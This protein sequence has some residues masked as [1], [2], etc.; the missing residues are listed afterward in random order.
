LAG[1]SV[2]AA[3]VPAGL[4]AATQA[5]IKALQ[6]ERRDALR[7]AIK[8]TQKAYEAGRVTWDSFVRVSRRLLD[9]ELALATTAAERIA[10]H[11]AHVA[12]LRNAEQLAKGRYEA[13]H[14][15]FAEYQIARAARA[16]GEIELLRAGGKLK[17]SGKKGK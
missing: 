13:G 9:A 8:A 11:E 4:D 10:A 3:P 15:I 17:K 14:L 5:Q 7:D 2:S 6:K 12:I 16:K 1:L